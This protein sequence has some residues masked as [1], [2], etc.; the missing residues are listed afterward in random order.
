MEY[1]L[2]LIGPLEGTELSNPMAAR[3]TDALTG[4]GAAVGEPHWLS[5]AVAVDIPFANLDP[6]QAAAAARLALSGARIDVAAQAA[7][8]REKRLLV[9][10]MDS[11]IIGEEC[12]D[13]LASMAGLG[14]EVAELT[15]AAMAG[16]IDFAEA[17]RQ[18]VALFAGLNV[19]L[20]Q[21]TYDERIHL[22][23]GA[24]TLVRTMEQH[25]A[26]TELVSGGFQFFTSRVAEAAGFGAFGGNVFEIIDGVLTGQVT[27]AIVGADA[28]REA[29]ERLMAELGIPRDQSLAV[30]DGANDIPMLEAAG[31]GVAMHPKP[32]VREAAHVSIYHGDLTA[33]LYLQGYRA[34]EFTDD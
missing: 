15:R 21:R 8:G 4:A 31:L 9:A 28:K 18:R 34:D 26:V 27:G 33:L 16:E 5:Q 23:A 32:L 13:E 6:A 22:N 17:L 7:S 14:G 12:L 24:R 10:D 3:V 11:T 25:G 19:A 1:V 2:T 20:L 29:L 30:G